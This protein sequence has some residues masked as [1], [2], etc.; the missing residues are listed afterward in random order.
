MEEAVA[1]EKKKGEEKRKLA[2]RV[3]ES[4]RSIKREPVVQFLQEVGTFHEV[5]LLLGEVIGRGSVDLW[6]SIEVRSSTVHL[7]C[8]LLDQ[9][10]ELDR[11]TTGGQL[12]LR[13]AL[14]VGG[15]MWD[16][17]GDEML[18]QKFVIT[19][20]VEDTYLGIVPVRLRVQAGVRPKGPKVKAVLG[21]VAKELI[22]AE[23]GAGAGAL[24][25]EIVT[26]L[27]VRV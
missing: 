16:S 25:T 2:Y 9:V 20:E 1:E 13:V 5:V 7:L 6:V 26:T 15:D 4:S 18:Y 19:A 3:G 21:V 12:S 24:V 14:L 8:F 22:E 17:V 10:G 27:L 23:A 11:V